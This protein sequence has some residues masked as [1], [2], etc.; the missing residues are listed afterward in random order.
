MFLLLH[1]SKITLAEVSVLRLGQY[2]FTMHKGLRLIAVLTLSIYSPFL[3]M[4]MSSSAIP[5]GL[6]STMGVC[7]KLL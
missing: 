7:Y 5:A 2:L 1:A 4:K 6:P 3:H